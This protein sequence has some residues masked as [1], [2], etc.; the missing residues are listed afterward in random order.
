MLLGFLAGMIGAVG[1]GRRWRSHVN[2]LQVGP[3]FGDVVL[4]LEIVC[5]R[6]ASSREATG[7]ILKGIRGRKFFGNLELCQYSLSASSSGISSSPVTSGAH[8]AFLM[9]SNFRDDADASVA[10]S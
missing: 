2:I 9:H 1:N 10:R 4:F 3:R 8:P 5:R 7:K 6:I